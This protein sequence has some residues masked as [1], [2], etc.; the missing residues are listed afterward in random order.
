MIKK[1]NKKPKEKLF[2]AALRNKNKIKV[3]AVGKTGKCSA[4]NGDESDA[5]RSV[6]IANNYIQYLQNN[7]GVLNSRLHGM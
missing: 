5:K 7:D 2:V 4:S 3:Q 1:N 6:R